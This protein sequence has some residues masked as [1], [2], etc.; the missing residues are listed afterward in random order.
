MSV[1]EAYRATEVILS[2]NRALDEAF[3]PTPST[4]DELHIKADDA[5]LTMPLRFLFPH[6]IWVASLNA[7]IGNATNTGVPKFVY[8][9]KYRGMNMKI[10]SISANAATPESDVYLFRVMLDKDY[11]DL[12]YFNGRLS[13][14][15]NNE[16]ID[17]HSETYA[18]SLNKGILSAI[19][20]TKR[21]I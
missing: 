16:I 14:S 6:G 3:N 4:P 5:W 8:E 17:I 13:F 1:L 12:L 2:S 19:V 18:N 10:I 20:R 21:L 7:N 11:F 15:V 9:G